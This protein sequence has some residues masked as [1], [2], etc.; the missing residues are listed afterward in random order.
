MSELDNRVQPQST[1]Q[2]LDADSS[3]QQAIQVVKSGNNLVIE[4][5]PG[6][7]KAKLLQI[8]LQNCCR[9]IKKCYL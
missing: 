3:Q 7:A 2:I 5:P 9:K 8:L 1:Y 4:G 6:T